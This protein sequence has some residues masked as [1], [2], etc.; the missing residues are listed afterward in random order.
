M[1]ATIAVQTSRPSKLCNGE[2]DQITPFC[3]LNYKSRT[4]SHGIAV[5]ECNSSVAG[6]K[7]HFYVETVLLIKGILSVLWPHYRPST[8]WLQRR[9]FL[10]TRL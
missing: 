6:K 5:K 10:L 7:V 8:E 2:R 4:P 3:S 1:W 9:H